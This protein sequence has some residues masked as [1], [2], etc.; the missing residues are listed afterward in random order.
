M[1]GIVEAILQNVSFSALKLMESLIIRV[2]AR[3]QIFMFNVRLFFE[4]FRIGFNFGCVFHCFQSDRVIHVVVAQ[5]E[6]VPKSITQAR[7]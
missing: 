6:L 4:V 7:S 5:V 2:R 1:S 3:S